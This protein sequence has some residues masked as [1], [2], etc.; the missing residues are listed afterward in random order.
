MEYPDLVAMYATSRITPNYIRAY[1]I[2]CLGYVAEFFDFFLVA[3]LLAVVRPLWHLTY[4][5]SSVVLLAA[6]AGAIFGSLFSG[7]LG[8]AFGRRKL[9]MFS[10]AAC[11][12]GAGGAVFLPDG[13][14]LAFAGLRFFVG[15]GLSGTA[16]TITVMVVE[17]TPL[18][19]RKALT[20]F[21]LTAASVGSVVASLSAATMI[22][23]LGWRGVAAFGFIPFLLL[24]LV[25]FF[26]PESPLWLV[27][28]GRFEEARRS[29][30][31]LAQRDVANLPVFVG[32]LDAR[33]P[34]S[35][36]AELFAFPM[37]TLMVFLTWTAL[38]T[39]NFGVYLWGPTVV[40]MMLNVT[41][42]AAAHYFLIVSVF[43]LVGRVVLSALPVW[44]SRRRLC[45][46]SG[47]FIAVALAGAGLYPRSFILG[48]PLFVVFVALGAFFF[49][50]I[51][52]VISPYVVGIYPTRL[53]GRAIGIGQAGNGV[54]K[55]I[56][57]LCLAVI[58]G[59]GQLVT[60]T[61]TTNAVTPA[62]LF[63][64]GCALFFGVG[65]AFLLP[66]EGGDADEIAVPGNA[67]VAPRGAIRSEEAGATQAAGVPP[68]LAR[69]Q[70][71]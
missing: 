18:R 55:I 4:G 24:I 45:A 5:Q 7:A 35:N 26:V 34:N 68:P 48:Y 36:L 52:V 71:R 29:F 1:A 22:D 63:M 69:M 25:F 27:S 14:W 30:G 10:M 11:A 19:F 21:P 38:S 44:V 15:V 40:S 12:I 39:T 32:D 51:W 28:K 31:I 37:R 65:F 6:G 54:G 16:T 3:Y 56:G 70:P 20:G 59:T 53:A 49:D 61:A 64:A 2:L 60:P 43:A 17:V 13:A 47:F 67:E 58:A 50:G 42:S 23:R 9:L 46:W 57:P 8:D 41:A 66:E 33:A 62:F